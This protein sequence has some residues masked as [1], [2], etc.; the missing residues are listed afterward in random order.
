MS[1][2]RGLGRI[3]AINVAAA[4]GYAL[5]GLVTL[6]LGEFQGLASPVWPAAGL[7]VGLVCVFGWRVVPGIAVGSL[8]ANSG[9]LLRNDI[10]VSTVVV[11]AGVIAVGAAL[12]ALAASALVRRYAGWPNGLD[13]ARPI[14]LFLALAGPVACVINPT[15]GV[16]AQFAT[17][18]VPGDAVVTAWTTWWVGDIVGVAVFGPLTLMTLPSQAD[19]WRGRRWKVA[20]PTV[21]LLI[22]YVGVILQSALADQARQQMAVQDLADEAAT[23]LVNNLGRHQEVL[24]GMRGL[25]VSQGDVS[26]EAFAEYTATVFDRYPSLQALSWNPVVTGD[27]LTAFEAEEGRLLGDPAYRV[28]QR[29]D[30]GELVPVQPRDWHV[31]VA[32]IEPL[33]LNRKA[34]GFDIRSNPVRSAAID[35]AIATGQPTA[36]A[37]VDL[38]Q[39]SGTQKGALALLPVYAEGRSTGDPNELPAGF[40][41]GV[42]RFGDLLASTHESALWDR[43]DL[44]LTDVTDAGQPVLIAESQANVPPAQS[45][46]AASLP[47]AESEPFAFYGRSWQITATP[48]SGPLAESGLPVP[49]PFLL[50]GAVAVLFLEAFLLLLSG[51]EQRARREAELSSYEASHDPL[52]GLLNRRAF[53]RQLEAARDRALDAE[54]PSML[55]FCDLDGFK[56]VNDLG[57]HDAGDRMLTGIAEVVRDCVRTRDVV[58][59]VG[60]DEFAL[61]LIDCPTEVGLRIARDIVASVQGFRLEEAGG[62]YAVTLSIGMVMLAPGDVMPADELMRCADEACYDAKRAGKGVV[63]LYAAA[64]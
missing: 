46:G 14:L 37:P 49:A 30:A 40:A 23:D 17:G 12:Q 58:A 6:A 7:A 35:M 9:T 55:L 1:G 25:L 48:T 63:R 10:E 53:L 51:T 21:L 15:I 60:G 16:A 59:R 38:V 34:L 57:G 50:L 31:P 2:Q 19:F 18:V 45:A 24:E 20:V 43:I 47:T 39:E 22:A 33:A 28:T 61:L 52:T 26:S 13:A 54:A 5:L 42:Y 36:T 27:Q 56:P 62:T 3:A 41:V 11:T 4:L 29:N 8:V 44:V 32:V 64:T